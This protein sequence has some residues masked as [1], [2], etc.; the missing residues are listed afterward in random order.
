MKNTKEPRHFKVPFSRRR[1]DRRATEIVRRLQ[2]AGFEAFLVGGCVRDLLLGRR[3]KDF[4]IATSAK[5]NA[6]RRLFRRSRMIGR[7]F[8]LVHVYVGREIYEVSTFRRAPQKSEKSKSDTKI[9]ADDNAYGNAREDALRRDFTVNALFMDP[10]KNE[11]LDWS[12]GMEDLKEKVLHSLG[13]PKIR[14]REDPVR[15]LR[16]IKFMRWLEF[17]PGE[18]EIEAARTECTHLSEA[19]PPRLVEEVF[20][21]LQTGD[22]EGVFQD[23][24]ALGVWK[25]LLPELTRWMSRDEKNFE[26]LL[27]RLHVLD[28]W[29]EEGG[30][31][32]YSL[33]L[34][35]LYGPYVEDEL[36]P[37]TR[38]LPMREP[39]QIVSEILRQLQQR[40]RLPRYALTRASRILLAQTRMDPLPSPKKR[41]RRFNAARLVENDWFDD[42]LEYLRGR[43]IADG[44][45]LALYDEWHE[46]ALSIR[47]GDR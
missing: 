18:Q 37:E 30:E 27:A 29:V 40:A 7:R 21:L 16:L 41:G 38:T 22:S 8:K 3:P 46:R 34:A 44:R 4:D 1:L 10:V 28:Q 13:D 43:L 24:Q 2:E 45:E 31:P 26:R 14:F 5:P 20:R 6:V 42:A 11:I 32:C 25:T 15:V 39:P 23:I 47:E 17:S 19:P 36:N 12:T 9:L 33:R 35:I